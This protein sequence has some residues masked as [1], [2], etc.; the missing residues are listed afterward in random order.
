MHFKTQIDA[1]D[2]QPSILRRSETAKMGRIGRKRHTDSSKAGLHG[3]AME[4]RIC[5]IAD[6]YQA[7]LPSPMDPF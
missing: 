7:G 1:T 3:P 5:K 4:Q 6:A 2:E